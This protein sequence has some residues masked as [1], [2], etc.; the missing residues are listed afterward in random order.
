VNFIMQICIL[1][2]GVLSKNVHNRN[3]K[4]LYIHIIITIVHM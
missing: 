2:S 1:R 3:N 4:Q